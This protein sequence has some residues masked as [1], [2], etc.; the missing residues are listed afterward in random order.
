MEQIVGWP[1]RWDSFHTAAPHSPS[2]TSGNQP[3]VEHPPMCTTTQLPT[4]PKTK[5]PEYIV[6]KMQA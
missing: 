5:V 4:L 6:L 3:H 1:H 2:A